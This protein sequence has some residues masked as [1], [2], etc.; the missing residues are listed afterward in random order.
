MINNKTLNQFYHYNYLTINGDK[1]VKETMKMI[2]DESKEETLIDYL[3]VLDKKSKLVGAL[4]LKDLIIARKTELIKDIMQT[5]FFSLKEETPIYEAID[6]IQNYDLEMI[7]ILNKQGAIKAVFTAESALDSLK[8]ETLQ[9]YRNIALIKENSIDANAFQKTFSRLPWLLALLLLSLLTSSVIGSFEETIKSVVVLVYFQTML[10]DMAG[11]VSTQSLASTV[12]KIAKE[13]KA[14][15]RKHVKKELLI[16]FLNSIFCGV[17]GFFSA[18]IF[19]VILREPSLLISG[20]VAVS[21]FAGLIIGT[22]SGALTPIL[23]KKLKVDPSVASGPFMTTIND[24]FSLIIY[25]SLA[26]ALLP[27]LA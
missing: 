12:I 7:P 4:P 17:F 10:L 5:K 25:L 2:I 13:P 26:T 1:T 27:Y 14:P 6:I 15:L 20:I 19:L 16:G 3:Y 21:L 11:N 18:Y 22:L 8:E 9:Q 23:F 24:V